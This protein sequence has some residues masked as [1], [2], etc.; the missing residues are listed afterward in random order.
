METKDGSLW[1]M[2]CKK[3]VDMNKNCINNDVYR[4]FGALENFFSLA[5]T[6]STISMLLEKHFWTAKTLAY[7]I[8]NRHSLPKS[9]ERRN[10]RYFNWKKLLGLIGMPYWVNFLIFFAQLQC[11]FS[12]VRLQILSSVSWTEKVP[13]QYFFLL[14]NTDISKWPLD[15]SGPEIVPSTSALL[16]SLKCF[17]LKWPLNH[18]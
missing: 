6:S 14:G 17:W 11:S 12:V 9:A 5:F 3:I 16:F 7:F 8:I 4:L 10:Q 1:V 18:I 2:K 13:C 15:S